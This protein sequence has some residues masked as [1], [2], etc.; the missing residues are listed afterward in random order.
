MKR[1]PSGL[2]RGLAVALLLAWLAACSSSAP[3]EEAASLAPLPDHWSF[4]GRA[5]AEAYR[6]QAWTGRRLLFEI[7]AS[8]TVVD[9]TPSLKR[10]ADPFDEIVLEIRALDEQGQILGPAWRHPTP[11]RRSAEPG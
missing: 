10:A 11:P 9:L 2:G 7:T 8:D 5:G 1:V 4:E 6:V 3:S